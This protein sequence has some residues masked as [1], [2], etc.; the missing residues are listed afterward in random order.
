[1]DL[2]FLDRGRLVCVEVKTALRARAGPWRPGDSWRTSAFERQRC[3][4]A[5]LHARQLARGAPSPRLDLV[6]VW[7]GPR[8]KRPE[9]CHRPGLERLPPRSP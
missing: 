6:E 7:I 5:E 3:A 2:V 8:G 1:V 4:A 9:I